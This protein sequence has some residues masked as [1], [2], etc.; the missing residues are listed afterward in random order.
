MK[1]RTL[2]LLLILSVITIF[3]WLNWNEFLTQTTLNLW[4]EK[5][6][7]PLG[8]VMLGLLV[9]LALIFF[10]YAL[11]LRATVFIKE[12]Q[13][14]KDLKDAREL[15]EKAEQSRFT[16]LRELIETENKKLTTNNTGLF[17]AIL[18]KLNKFDNDFFSAL[19][20]LRKMH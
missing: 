8:L 13:I 14:T 6:Q 19:N 3:I 15:A 4:I 7:A 1:I 17:E 2:F 18:A 5:V 11:Y 10:I 12:R 9:L 20:E 16:E